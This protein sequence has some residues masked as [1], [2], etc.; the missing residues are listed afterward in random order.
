[1][2]RSGRNDGVCGDAIELQLLVLFYLKKDKKQCVI[3]QLVKP[4][5]R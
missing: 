3:L 1:M 5:I 4:I 2:D